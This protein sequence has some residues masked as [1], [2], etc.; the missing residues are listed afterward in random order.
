MAQFIEVATSDELADQQASKLIVSIV[1]FIRRAKCGRNAA[2][3]AECPLRAPEEAG[4][5]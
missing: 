1:R 4:H 5:E 3:A 2:R